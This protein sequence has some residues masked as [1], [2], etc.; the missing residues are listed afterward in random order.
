MHPDKIAGLAQE[1]IDEV[2][3]EVNSQDQEV[4][5]QDH[6]PYQKPDL[7]DQE[8]QENPESEIQ[9]EFKTDNNPKTEEEC[10]PEDLPFDCLIRTKLGRISRQRISRYV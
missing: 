9:I 8:D 2:N 3:Q 1:K 4:D 6:A 10:E 5:N 7:Q